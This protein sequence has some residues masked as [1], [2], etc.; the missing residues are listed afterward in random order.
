MADKDYRYMASRIAEIAGRVFCLTPDNPRAL[1]AAD[2]AAVFKELGIAA[3][4]V[5]TV[6]KAVTQA[7]D[8]ARETN[9]P[10]VCLGSLY[11]YHEIKTALDIT[12]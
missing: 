5:S 9:T 11:M 6:E 3:T 8:W 7:L 4:A 12:K 2:Y 1:P 10:V